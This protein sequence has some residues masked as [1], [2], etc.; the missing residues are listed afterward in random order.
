MSLYV[1]KCKLFKGK[2]IWLSWTKLSRKFIETKEKGKK[3]IAHANNSLDR[4]QFDVVHL[5][6]LCLNYPR[7]IHGFDY[8]EV[9]VKLDKWVFI[10][11]TFSNQPA[12]K[13]STLATQPQ[14]NLKLGETW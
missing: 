6:V 12:G 11:V 5:N 7:K 2:I 13:V 4:L 14:Q 3:V 1:L 8:P 10:K 9:Q